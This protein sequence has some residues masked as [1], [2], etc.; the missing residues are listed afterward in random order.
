MGI[1]V[2]KFLLPARESP[3]GFIQI[4]L[5]LHVNHVRLVLFSLFYN[6]KVWLQK[7]KKY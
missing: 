2:K 1:K 7:F 5:A 4:N 6:K 3:K